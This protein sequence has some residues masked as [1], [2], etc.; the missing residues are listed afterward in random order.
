MSSN[1]ATA[2]RTSNA[3]SPGLRTHRMPA[4]FCVLQVG[5]P[6]DPD[7]LGWGYGHIGPIYETN[8]GDNQTGGG[9]DTDATLSWWPIRPTGFS[10]MMRGKTCEAVLLPPD[11]LHGSSLHPYRLI[12]LGP[13]PTEARW[14]SSIPGSLVTISQVLNFSS[15]CGAAADQDSSLTMSCHQPPGAKR[16]EIR[17]Y[18]LR[19]SDWQ[20]F[21]IVGDTAAFEG[22]IVSGS[23]L[24]KT[25]PDAS[26]AERGEPQT[27]RCGEIAFSTMD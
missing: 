20:E 17:E 12:Q 2:S 3:S 8:S 23:V 24:L 5:L 15:A 6:G 16:R 11:S 18:A 19:S 4:H 22:K 1:S 9:S 13:H 21:V 26:D 27:F 10:V 7:L 25:L 14:K